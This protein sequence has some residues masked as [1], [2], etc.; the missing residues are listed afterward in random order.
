MHDTL[1]ESVKAWIDECVINETSIYIKGW[2]FHNDLPLLQLR[3]SGD[4]HNEFTDANERF[5]VNQYYNKYDM[6]LFQ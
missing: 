5:D 6:I 2:T 1:L 3:V 4:S